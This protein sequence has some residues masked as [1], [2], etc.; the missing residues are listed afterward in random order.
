[1]IKIDKDIPP[2]MTKLIGATLGKLEIGESFLIEKLDEPARQT[3]FR[4]SRELKAQGKL[5]TSMMEE[6]GVR[7]WRL[8]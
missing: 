2:P 8:A 5:F 3:L 1:M 7:T 4:K 6:D